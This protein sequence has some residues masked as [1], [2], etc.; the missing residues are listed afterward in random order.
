MSEHAAVALLRN[1]LCDSCM[2]TSYFDSLIC[3]AD[4]TWH[5][6]LASCSM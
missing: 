4:M 2:L 1:L 6:L 5:T 3:S